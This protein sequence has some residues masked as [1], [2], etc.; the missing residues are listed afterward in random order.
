[1]RLEYI[2]TWFAPV[3]AET[4][5]AAEQEVIAEPHELADR[6]TYDIH[7]GFLAR[8]KAFGIPVSG[9]RVVNLTEYQALGFHFECPPL[10]GL[11][12]TTGMRLAVSLRSPLFHHPLDWPKSEVWGGRDD[13]LTLK[14]TRLVDDPSSMAEVARAVFHIYPERLERTDTLGDEDVANMELKKGD[15]ERLGVIH[16]KLSQI[17]RKRPAR[18]Y[19]LARLQYGQALHEGLTIV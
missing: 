5:L 13:F 15:T 4:F 2:N 3:F 8:V 6:E 17:Y 7:H 10:R 11:E 16:Y 12:K 9:D 18:S 1:M 19:E 14:I